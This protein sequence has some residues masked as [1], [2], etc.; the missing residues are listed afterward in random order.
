MAQIIDGKQISQQLRE[1]MKQEV[2]ELIEQGIKPCLAVIIVGEDP[3]SKVYVRNKE[4]ACKQLGM[5]SI[6]LRLPEETSQQELL[7]RVRTL[8]A[9]PAVNGILVQLPLPKH[10]DEQEV[11]REISPEKDVDGFHALNAGRLLL[12]E[13]CT[14]ACTPAGCLELIRSTGVNIS[15]A[16][17]VVVGRSNIVGKPMALLLLQQNATVTVCHSRTRNLGDITRRADILVAA[18]GKPRMITGDMIKPGAVVID[19]GINRVDGKLVGDVDFESA[20]EVAGWITPVPGGV[21]PMTIT[22]LMRNTIDA[23]RR[24]HGIK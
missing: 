11:L 18:V 4:R 9:D 3:A 15:G 14:V 12:G 5:D 6:L 19:V 7:E 2:A 13:Q 23:T 24:Q 10:L 21:G 17:A 20:C 22:G 16:E 1:G 8:N